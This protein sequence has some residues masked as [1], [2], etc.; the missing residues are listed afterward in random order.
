MIL[1]L[2]IGM[3]VAGLMALVSGKFTLI[4]NKTITGLSARLAGL[5]LLLPLPLSFVAGL[6]IALA[7]S[8]PGRPFNADA[9]KGSFALL[10]LAIALACLLVSGGIYAVARQRFP[11]V[12]PDARSRAPGSSP[13]KEAEEPLDVLPVTEPAAEEIRGGAPPRLPR[14][15]PP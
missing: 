8:A 4:K 12:R 2:E 7:K 3:L 14:V 13:A 6:V 9:F 10:E 11:Q 1:G 15:G 5:V